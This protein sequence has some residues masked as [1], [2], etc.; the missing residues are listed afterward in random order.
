MNK[1]NNNSGQHHITLQ[2][3]A[4][5][6]NNRSRVK[7]LRVIDATI[8]EIRQEIMTKV[9]MSTILSFENLEFLPINVIELNC[10]MSLNISLN[11][12]D[13]SNILN[14]EGYIFNAELYILSK[15]VEILE[16]EYSKVKDSLTN[17]EFI[18]NSSLEREIDKLLNNIN[19]SIEV[20]KRD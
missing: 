4:Q 2:A 13:I 6:D 5:F 18:V 1:K 8:N 20:K 11:N 9:Q 19:Y 10:D 3:I 14:E 15:D 16:R 7:R 12:E 17:C